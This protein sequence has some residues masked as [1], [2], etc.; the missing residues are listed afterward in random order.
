VKIKKGI[1]IAAL[2]FLSIFLFLAAGTG[3]LLPRNPYPPSGKTNAEGSERGDTPFPA[4]KVAQ[5]VGPAVVGITALTGGDF[6]KGGVRV[7]QGTGVIIEGSQGYVVTNYHVI[8]G[9][10]RISASLDHDRIYGATVVDK[11]ER[12]DLAVLK[13]PGGIYPKSVW[14]TRRGSRWGRR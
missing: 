6:F 11:D 14:A 3:R 4:V 7:I 9:A 13:I 8:A 5:E 2:V 1:P 12:S 10:Q